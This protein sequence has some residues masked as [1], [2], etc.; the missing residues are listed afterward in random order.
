[1]SLTWDVLGLGAAAVDDLLYVDQYPVPDSKV[2]VQAKER[3]GGGLAGT[4]LVA[5]ARLGAAVAYC[6]VLGDDDLSQYALEEF[7]REGI[8]CTPVMNDPSARPIHSI[9]IVDRT[10]GSR[11]MLVFRA[12]PRCAALSRFPD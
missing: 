9:V 7:K 8:D 5:A 4:A 1:M 6:G 12:W 2:P 11:S 3:H 10:T